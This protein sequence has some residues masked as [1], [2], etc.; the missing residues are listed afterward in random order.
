MLEEFFKSIKGKYKIKMSEC[1]PEPIFESDWTEAIYKT[2]WIETG[3]VV[4]LVR[5]LYPRVHC[6][7]CHTI[8]YASMEHYV[9]GDW[10]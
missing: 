6:T 10:W 9:M 3:H 4:Q 1:H 2:P 7:K 5:K 8:A